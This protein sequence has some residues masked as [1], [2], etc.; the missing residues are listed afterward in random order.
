MA[1]DTNYFSGCYIGAV[2]D[3]SQGSIHPRAEPGFISAL[4]P[5][6]VAIM[7]IKE[8]IDE[9]EELRE[10]IE[11]LAEFT[12]VRNRTIIGL[13]N[14]LLDGNRDDLVEDAIYWKNKFERK[15][16]RNQLF[17]SEQKVYV[18]VLAFICT[19]FNSKIL[20][21]IRERQKNSVIDSEIYDKIIKEVHIALVH[22]DNMFT[23]ELI[24][25]MLFYLTGKCHL[26]WR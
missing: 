9:T 11:D 10:F 17:L 24:R 14:K 15:L 1:G 20:P 26:V 7:S 16:A 21:L 12:T 2:G 22:Y 13:E 19:A 3:E 23:T 6:H 5:L 18:Q 8:K 4:S 25:G